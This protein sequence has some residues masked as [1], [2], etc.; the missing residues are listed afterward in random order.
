MGSEEDSTARRYIAD[1]MRTQAA[2][3]RRWARNPFCHSPD[4]TL[5]MAH[6]YDRAARLIE[7]DPS[8]LIAAIR[9]F[10]VDASGGGPNGEAELELARLGDALAGGD[11]EVAGNAYVRMNEADADRLKALRVA[12]E[13]Y[14]GGDFGKETK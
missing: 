14:F 2:D 3:T 10:T 13:A 9:A 7:A 5:A 12:A 11:I 8:Q 4:E 6:E 1:G